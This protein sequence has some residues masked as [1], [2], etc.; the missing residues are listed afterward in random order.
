[1]KYPSLIFSNEGVKEVIDIVMKP[2]DLSFFLRLCF[3]VASFSAS[4]QFTYTID[5]RVPVE[6]NGTKLAMAWAGGLNSA[7]VN[8]IDVNA[9][10]KPDIVLFDK[11]ANRIWTFVQTQNTYRYAPEYESLFPP[12]VYAFLLLR[13]YN[14]DGKKDLFTFNSTVNGISVYQNTTAAGGNLSWKKQ[15]FKISTGTTEIL[16][17]KGFSGFINI[18]PG[19]DDIPNITDMDGDG[20]LDIVNMRFVNPS[21]AEYHKNFAK[22]RYGRCDTLV[23]ERQTQRWGDWEECSCGVIA[24]GQTCDQLTGGGRQ[25]STGRTEH[26]GGKALLAIDMDNDGNKDILYSEEQCNRIYYMRNNGTSEM[27]SMSAESVFPGSLPVAFPFFPAPF[28][29]DVDFDG[30]PDFLASPNLNSRTYFNTNFN[31]SLHYYKNTGTAQ[32]PVFTYVKN[33]FLQDQMIDVGDN[34]VPAFADADGDGDKD[35]FIGTFTSA[36]FTGRIMLY[37]NNGTVADPS[38]RFVTDDY[39]SLSLPQFYNI[40]P[41]FADVN[42]DGTLDLVFTATGF[43]TGVTS[44]YYLP[45]SSKD[46]ITVSG[47]NY[48]PMNFN[49]SSTENILLHD[50]NGD[51]VLDLLIGKS[52][53]ALNY[54]ENSGPAGSFN[55]ALKNSS[56]LNLGT[57]TSRQN[58]SIA[59]ADLDADG[60]EDLITGDQQGVLT[61]YNNFRATNPVPE[62]STNSILDVLSDTFVKKNL[63]GRVWPVAVNLFNEN[64]PSIVVG[65][66]TGGLY[67]LKSDNSHELAP[68]PVISISPNPVKRGE[69]LTIIADRNVSLQI[70]SVLGQKMSEPLFVPANQAYTLPIHNLAAGMYIIH[71]PVSKSITYS[72]KFIVY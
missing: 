8:T 54:Y 40:R 5:Q 55:F 9:D 39:A 23:F 18:L 22:E 19:I 72:W 44:L 24:F 31:H 1:M 67:L 3:I 41:Q 63:G 16:L 33:N 61:I 43:T 38:F 50:V 59:I 17:T 42:A 47:S 70:F 2:F 30:V 49:L 60:N 69:N 29:E 12:E 64:K 35:M 52:T 25:E 68:D 71:A 21:T 14:C 46:K 26:N 56:Y 65:N 6:V 13:D 7:Q 15:E 32:Q 20:D 11:G 51:G 10:N 48:L 36:D 27:A 34:S 45:N 58:L 57:S 53:G 4:A 28:Q 62:G 37:E 66:T